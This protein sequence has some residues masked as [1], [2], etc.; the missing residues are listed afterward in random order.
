M[1]WTISPGR[2]AP[3]SELTRRRP[4]VP[5]DTDPGSEGPRG[6]PAVPAESD[7]GPRSC[8]VDQLS[9]PTR[10]WVRAEV[11]STS[12]P[13]NSDT[14]L[15]SC[16]D[17]QLSRPI[18]SRV[19]GF[20]GSAS[21]HRRLGSLSEDLLGRPAI[22]A[23]SVPGPSCRGVDQLSWLILTPGLRGLRDDLRS[24]RLGLVS[25]E[26]WGRPAIPADSVPDPS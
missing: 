24:G 4:A 6:R 19:R 1:G 11:G 22:P 15:R 12:C 17:V 18:G 8:W 26:E 10:S 2:L 9:R 23:H 21:C 5:A 13:D 3:V 16:G 7:P 14:G 25:E 20:L